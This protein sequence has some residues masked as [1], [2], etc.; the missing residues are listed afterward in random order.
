MATSILRGIAQVNI[1]SDDVREARDWYFRLLGEQPYFERPD[2]TNPMYVEFRLGDYQHEL[3]IV[4]RQFLPT[5]SSSQPCGAITRWHVDDLSST[6]QRLEELGATEHEP[7]TEREGGFATASVV[8]PF[9]N[10]L[11]L[12]TSPHYLERLASGS[13]ADQA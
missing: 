6:V 1:S 3:G 7:L 10:I 12:I 8:D 2:S 4:H 11:G 5:P 9:G 13:G